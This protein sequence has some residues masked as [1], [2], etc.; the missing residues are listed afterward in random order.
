MCG[1]RI[2]TAILTENMSSCVFDSAEQIIVSH[3]NPSA[4]NGMI[5]RWGE[6]LPVHSIPGRGHQLSFICYI[7]FQKRFGILVCVSH[8]TQSILSHKKT[9]MAANN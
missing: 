8:P 3:L 4:C 1:V 2:V 9:M 7:T 5:V 6:Y